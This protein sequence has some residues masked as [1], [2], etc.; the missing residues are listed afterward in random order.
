MIR[1]VS[2]G[3]SR[4]LNERSRIE[5]CQSHVEF[6]ADKISSIGES[7]GLNATQFGRVVGWLKRH[8]SL[9]AEIGSRYQSHGLIEGLMWIR[10]VG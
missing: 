8:R 3:E 1:I 2:L 7:C 4:G 5:R 10:V 6:L 9:V